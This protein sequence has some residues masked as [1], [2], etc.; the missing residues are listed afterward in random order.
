MGLGLAEMTVA[1]AVWFNAREFGYGHWFFLWRRFCSL[2][3]A[4]VWCSRPPRAWGCVG[5]VVWGCCWLVRVAAWQCACA[6]SKPGCELEQHIA[7]PS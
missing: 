6:Q 4:G 2:L 3:A 1:A 7:P 5:A